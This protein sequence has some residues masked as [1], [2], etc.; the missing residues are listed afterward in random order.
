M[1]ILRC[2][3]SELSTDERDGVAELLPELLEEPGPKRRPVPEPERQVAEAPAGLARPRGDGRRRPAGRAAE[4]RVAVAAQP[5]L[6]GRAPLLVRIVERLS[7]PG[8]GRP[9]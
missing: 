1:S 6:D 4:E 8:A 9:G 7:A 3:A 2:G 5:R